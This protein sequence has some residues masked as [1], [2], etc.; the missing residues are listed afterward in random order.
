MRATRA[1]AVEA[2]L[3]AGNTGNVAASVDA[4]VDSIGAGEGSLPATLGELA[5]A[6][7]RQVDLGQPGAVSQM[8]QVL[9]ALDEAAR[10]T[11]RSGEMFSLFDIWC[12]LTPRGVRRRSDV[13]RA[14]HAWMESRGMGLGKLGPWDRPWACPECGFRADREVGRRRGRRVAD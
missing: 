9:E 14:L 11:Q 1:V 5:R 8:R 4:L 2:E 12:A 13:G 3:A 6:T 7:A 10:L